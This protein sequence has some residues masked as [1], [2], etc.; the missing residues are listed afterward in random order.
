M[1]D[2]LHTYECRV[3]PIDPLLFGDNRSARAGLDHIRLDQDLSPHTLHGA[4]GQ[5]LA[6][7]TPTWPRA[8]LGEKVEDVFGAK[9]GSIA[10]LL[11]FALEHDRRLWF[12]CPRHLRLKRRSFKNDLEAIELLTPRADPDAVTSTGD[13][14]LLLHL[15][16]DDE[17]ETDVLVD[18]RLLGDVLQ[19]SL[20]ASVA[21]RTITP[22][23]VYARELRPGLAIDAT[24]GV[25]AEGMLFT[26][27]YRRFR[28]AR[29]DEPVE[30]A[31]SG[32]CAW[33]ATPGEIHPEGTPGPAGTAY[34]GGDR[35]RVRMDFS[36]VPD[37]P[38]GE[39]RD[40]IVE[41]AREE[42]T[43][44][45]LVYLLTPALASSDAPR[46]QGAD[47]VA[48]ALGKPRYLSGW[49]VALGRP[50][51]LR[52]VIP[53]G[54]VYF[55]RWPEGADR[56]RLVERL[57]LSALSEEGDAAGFGR[58]LSGVWSCA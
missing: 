43:D 28:T 53:P 23:E 7:R 31:D 5:F 34:L 26:R 1:A 9:R 6:D 3:R 52:T 8:M 41:S 20:G 19:G 47:A 55:Y 25:A 50:R 40:E 22:T 54:S 12:P 44:G 46:V 21:D 29:A 35:G 37:W 42:E 33:L 51:E 56:G 32:I 30:A 45:F 4:I 2:P 38:L 27:P 24:T 48:A 49:N 14:E 57:W 17:I 15:I 36:P 16:E 11:G 39:L 10:S 58:V 13:P 18:L